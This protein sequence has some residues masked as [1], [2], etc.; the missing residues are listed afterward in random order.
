MCRSVLEHLKHPEIVFSEVRRVLTSEGRMLFLT[1]N[2]WD[3]VS[4]GSSLIPN[5]LHPRLVKLM[6]GRL[7]NNT[8][9]TFYQANTTLRLRFLANQAGLEVVSLETLREHPHYLQFNS[10]AY[11]LGLVYEQLLQRRVKQLRPWILGVLRRTEEV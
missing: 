7:E 3:Y 4:L 8:F 6:T 2:W 9:P 11:S 1:P 5:R 10:L